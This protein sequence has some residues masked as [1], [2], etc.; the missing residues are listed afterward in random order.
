MNLF[1]LV[2]IIV[3]V[4]FCLWGTIKGFIIEISEIGG[5]IISFILAIYLPLGLEM[6]V[7]KYV[8]SFLV[9]FFTISIFFSIL[10]KIIHKTPLAFFDRML[11]AVVGAIKGIIVVTIL[12]LIVSL[13]PV[14]E[15]HSNL[16]DSFFYKTA[17]NVKSPLKTFLKGRIK[18]LNHYKEKIPLPQKKEDEREPEDK[19]IKI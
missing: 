12:F 9:Y 19:I 6:G 18:G 10:S 8:V 4:G 15:T 7:V 14:N 2:S 13:V 1:D 11:G 17:I 5:L 16:S 3:I